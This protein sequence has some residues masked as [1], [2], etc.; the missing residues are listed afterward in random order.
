MND[1]VHRFDEARGVDEVRGPRL[2]LQ[3]R[4]LGAEVIGLAL[5][6]PGG[7][8]GLL[9]RNGRT[10][11]PPRWWK[12]HATV[13]FPIVGGIHGHRSRT[14]D[15]VEVAFR[16]LHGFARHSPFRLDAVTPRPD[17]LDLAYVL[18]ANAE[19][20]AGFPFEFRL[21]LTYGLRADRLI[22]TATVANPG[23]VPLPFQLGWHPGFNTP[24]L[25]GDKRDC[26]LRLPGGHLTRRLNDADCKLTGESR[27]DDV[28]GDFRFTEAELDA[29]YM[30]D[31][32][33]VAPADR[34]VELSDPD[35]AIGVRVGFPDY[36]HLGLWSDAGAPFLCIEPWQGMDDHATQEPFDRKFGMVLLPP[37]A[38]ETRR[39]WIEVLQGRALQGAA[40]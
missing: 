39:A 2:D 38:E 3:V 14:T 19:T 1:Y 24:F 22:Q 20:R 26:R 16:G 37:G 21:E 35:G 13:L 25:A 11:E 5:K 36:P 31:L 23:T 17:G 32:A 29:T 4:R 18:E 7:E 15:G 34:V 27:R 6:R 33:D 40:L 9:W 28:S 30:F 12:S 8:V 10:D